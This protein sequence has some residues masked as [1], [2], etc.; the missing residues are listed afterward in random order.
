MITIRGALTSRTA[1]RGGRLYPCNAR[2]ALGTA[3]SLVDIARKHRRFGP[4]SQRLVAP[5]A[6][7]IDY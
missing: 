6:N 1:N 2:I 5:D 4:A 7:G 3:P